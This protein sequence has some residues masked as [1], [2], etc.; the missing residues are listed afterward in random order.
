MIKVLKREITTLDVSENENDDEE[1]LSPLSPIISADES[2]QQDEKKVI[3]KKQKILF[4][5]NCFFRISHFNILVN[6]H[7]IHL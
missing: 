5:Q 7:Q 6:I 1:S 4:S 3:S 2:S